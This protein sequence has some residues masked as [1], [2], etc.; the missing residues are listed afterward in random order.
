MAA[1]FNRLHCSQPAFFA[2]AAAAVTA[3]ILCNTDSCTT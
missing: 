3:S 1:L 2:T